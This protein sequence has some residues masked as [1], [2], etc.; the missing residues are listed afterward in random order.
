[1]NIQRIITGLFFLMLAILS[2][3][4]GNLSVASAEQPA[5]MPAV[6]MKTAKSGKALETKPL[7]N[8]ASGEQL[9]QEPL[10][11]DENISAYS[12]DAPDGHTIGCILP[13]SGRYHND[14]N[15]ALDAILLAFGLF[16]GKS[17]SPW[18]MV[19]EDN[20]GLPDGTRA[21]LVN[22]AKNRKVMAIIA[23]VSGTE[24][25]EVV[26]EADKWKLPVILITPKEGVIRFS[27]YAF[28]HF[29]TPSQQIRALTNYALDNL[30]CAIFSV[31][32]PKDDYGSEMVKFF[33]SEVDR[34]GGKVERAVSYNKAQTDFTE[35]I[36]KI[37]SHRAVVAKQ[38]QSDKAAM[39]MASVDFEA[40]FIPDSYQ[41][42]KMIASQLV[43]YDIR[44]IRLLGT[45]LWNAPGLLK[46]GAEYL[47]GAVFADS[48]F[49]NSFYPEVNDFVDIYYTAYSREPE[50]IE[51][52]AY[53]T[54][55]MI[56]S[57]LKDGNVETREQFIA[58]LRQ[59]KNYR[60]VTGI[61][62]FGEDRVAQKTAF[63]LQVK[64]GKL[65][66]VK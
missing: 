24:A 47:E 31:L 40:L 2:I 60:G 1:M 51:A 9:R 13:L 12:K 46:N 16:D 48:F 10:K 4:G 66:Q 32:Y 33:R 36:N 65:E 25:V 41:R 59:L 17:R 37:T 20:G 8:N 61:T 53:D 22:L 6:Q 3:D 39:P 7:I 54:A 14:G 34:I 43:F 27:I 58:G 55:G 49:V 35:E 28:Q 11:Q 64:N 38:V 52:L 56:V 15:K 57:V 45:S 18:K 42:V 63:I 23:V 5:T 50:N 30:N 29:L 21:A 44:G 26:P 62:S 19:I